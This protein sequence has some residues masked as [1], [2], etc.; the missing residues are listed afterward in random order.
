MRAFDLGR[1]ANHWSG[2]DHRARSLLICSATL[3]T[4]MNRPYFS[5]KGILEAGEGVLNLAYGLIRLA[6]RLELRGA[7]WLCEGCLS[8][9][10]TPLG[11]R[12]PGVYL[13]TRASQAR[14]E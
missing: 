9:K 11:A 7:P 2:R 14:L 3:L 5:R 10:R 1:E 8:P 6:F 13:G 12:T 4:A